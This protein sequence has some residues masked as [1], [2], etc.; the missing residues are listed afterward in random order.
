M[1]SEVLRDRILVFT[2]K[3]DVIELPDGATPLDFAYAVHTAIGNHATGA[4]VNGNAALHPL[5]RPLQSGDIVE[6]IVDQKRKGPSS[7]WLSFVRTT[8]ARTK[9]R[10]ALR[11]TLKTKMASWMSA[12]MPRRRG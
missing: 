6:V 3:G 5:D 4:R 8:N 11:G 10:D 7:D 9:I 1:R 12:A 2:P